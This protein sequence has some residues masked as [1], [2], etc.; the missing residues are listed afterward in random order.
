MTLWSE[1]VITQTRGFIRCGIIGLAWIIA[2]KAASADSSLETYCLGNAWE[3][4]FVYFDGV[5]ESGLAADI[6]P[7]LV[8]ASTVFLNSPGGNL[9]EAIEVG[10]LIRQS[11]MRTAI[12]ALDSSDFDEFDRPVD[13]PENG[14]CESACA[15]LFMGGSE[16][17]ISNGRLGLHRFYSSERGLSSDEAQLL[18]GVLVEYL[19]EM[20]VDARVFLA[21]SRES[22]SGMYYL[23]EDEGLEY[24]VIT[25]YGYD[26]LFL[27]PYSGGIIASARRLAPT[28][29]YDQ[30]DQIT[31]FCRAGQPFVLLHAVSGYTTQS[32]IIRAQLGDSGDVEIPIQ[33]I[34]A[35]DAGNESWLTI[36]I[37]EN[38]RAFINE[39]INTGS[40]SV[41]VQYPRAAG[42]TYGARLNLSPMDRDMI[43]SAFMHCIN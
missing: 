14:I 22:A 10:R 26:D 37:P 23:T 18:S 27:E 17:T 6:A 39:Q 30:V 38:G 41:W 29:P 24:D 34:T 36:P 33:S 9:Q 16:R 31:F 15:Y 7:L 20:G 8:D 35:R 42:G 2:G 19:V 1:D 21:A 32:N 11:G 3:S 40:F 25:P 4:C 28:R 13:F 5:I 12:G 43:R